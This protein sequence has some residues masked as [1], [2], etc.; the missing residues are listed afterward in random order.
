M[1]DP[2]DAATCEAF[3][4]YRDQIRRDSS[5]VISEQIIAELLATVVCAATAS[6]RF[7]AVEVSLFFTRHFSSST[8][9]VS[10]SAAFVTLIGPRTP[11]LAY[12][13]RADQDS[14]FYDAALNDFET[15]KSLSIPFQ[16]ATALTLPL[17]VNNVKTFLQ[18]NHLPA[19]N[20]DELVEEIIKR[21]LSTDHK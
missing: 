5:P 6:Q 7:P 3:R 11:A 1:I 10:S 17:T 19:Y 12:F 15:M 9:D 18:E 16:S 14:T 13:N 20:N 2:S 8:V 4:A 21:A